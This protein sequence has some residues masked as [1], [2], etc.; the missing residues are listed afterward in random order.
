MPLLPRSPRARKR[1][2]WRSLTA[3][4]VLTVTLL[5]IFFRNTGHTEATPH[6]NEPAVV[7]HAPKTVRA[8]ASARREAVRTLTTF[9]RSAIIRR[10]LDASWPLADPRMKDGVSHSDWL[11]GNLP[12]APYDAHAFRSAGATPRYSYRGVLGY[13]VLI[14]PNDSKAGAES[15]QQV[16]SCELHHVRG[17]W[18]VDFCYP[19][20]TL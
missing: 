20:K 12:V 14:L 4:T 2:L 13:D 18:L 11:A 1:L 6:T 16:Y 7:L 17:R 15:G 19:R 8:T 10:N 9:A 3:V 5:L